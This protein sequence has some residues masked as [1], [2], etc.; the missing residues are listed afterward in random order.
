MRKYPMENTSN[1]I[2]PTIKR[3][4]EKE[5]LESGVYSVTLLNKMY[6]DI[7]NIAEV[8]GISVSAV[9]EDALLKYLMEE[10]W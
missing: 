6:K 7:S 2:K 1:T 9:I 5:Q 8:K 4:A 3:D 10:R